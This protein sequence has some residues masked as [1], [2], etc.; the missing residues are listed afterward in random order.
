MEAKFR[1][2][3]KIEDMHPDFV[4]W[5]GSLEA[6]TKWNRL[7]QHLADDA[8]EA[9]E[10]GYKTE[11]LIDDY[12]LLAWETFHV[13]REM[14]VV[15]P[16]AFPTDLDGD[17]E[18]IW[19]DEARFEALYEALEDYPLTST[20]RRLYRALN[21]VYGFYA[22]Y[23]SE[24]V[25]HND[26]DRADTEAENIEPELLSLAACKI[27][28]DR[29]LAPNF[30][31]F[32]ARTLKNYRKWLAIVKDWA[33]QT[34]IPLRVELMDMVYET[35][36]SLSHDAEAE[37][38]G[39]NADRIH[40]DVYMNELLTGMRVIHQVLP[41]ILKKLGIDDEFKLDTSQLRLGSSSSDM[42]GVDDDE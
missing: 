34:G 33:F 38:L 36:D 21:D 3:T 9:A 29:T 35:S 13:L 10:T 12:E 42:Q 16:S 31:A 7:I 39:F 20:I 27:D 6:A 37:S 2:L 4:L 25:N 15:I 30:D 14:G 24:L 32:R 17:Y 28:V 19:K 18:S 11:P 23:V 26:F 40:P 41:A 8:L 1:E 5:A 22:A